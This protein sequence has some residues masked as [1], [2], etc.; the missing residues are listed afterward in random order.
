MPRAGGQRYCGRGTSRGRRFHVLKDFAIAGVGGQ[1]GLLATTVLAQVFAEAGFDVKTSEVHGMAQ[2]GGTVT[3]YVRRGQK[4]FSPAVPAG[5]IDVIVGLELLEAYRELPNLKPS[6]VVVSSDEKIAP[7]SVITGDAEYPNL[8]EESFLQR[9]GE[10]YILPAL[11]MALEAGNVRTSN[12]VCLGALSWILE[13]P[14]SVWENEISKLVPE[15]TIDANLK[16]FCMGRRWM[17]KRR[18]PNIS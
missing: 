8:T 2:R 12:M 16:A 6:G 5:K 14:A 11:S 1:G 10:V 4:V 3:S 15:K 13:I 7:I 17:E 9:A 18:S